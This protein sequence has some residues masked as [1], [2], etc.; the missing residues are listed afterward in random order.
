[1]KQYAIVVAGGLGTRMGS[2]VPKQ[3]LTLKGKPILVHSIEKF[4]SVDQLILVLPKNHLERWQE[5]K[6]EFFPEV[7]I[8]TAIGG[9]SRTESVIS[10]LS[11]IPDD[12]LV[13]IHDA[14]RPFVNQRT[15]KA[16]Y[17]SAK[18]NGSGVA[19]V[20]LKDSIRELEGDKDS[21]HRDRNKYRLIQTP[22]TF[23]VSE[24]KKAYEVRKNEEFSDDASVY[25]NAGYKVCLVEG[26]YNNIKITTPEDLD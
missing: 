10:G 12:G 3:F 24:I 7:E 13:A 25:E 17:L 23:R 18:E 1:M 5:L 15:I 16:S 8:Q 19:S 21:F 11:L 26:S 14:V 4:L 6:K 9:S 2:E 22:Q 20:A